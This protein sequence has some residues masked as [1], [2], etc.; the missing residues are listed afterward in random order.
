MTQYRTN[1]PLGSMA[2]RDLFD[3]AQN[4]DNW[5]NG[6]EPFYEDR[7]GVMRR[8]FSGMNFEFEAAQEGRTAAFDSSQADKES[9]F[10]ALMES[11]AYVSKGA[12]AEGVV[13]EAYNEYVAVDAATTGVDAAFYRP[14]PNATLPLTLSG[15]WVTDEPFLRLLGDDVLR[16]ELADVNG[17]LLV[18]GAVATVESIETLRNFEPSR[19]GQTVELLGYYQRGIG[20]GV[21][22]HDATSS[23]ADDG[24][25]TIVTTGGNRWVRRDATPSTPEMYGAIGD[26]ETDDTLA[27]HRWWESDQRKLS[28]SGRYRISGS[29][30]MVRTANV[31]DFFADLRAST[32]E[33]V[34]PRAYLFS[35]DVNNDGSSVY[36]FGGI[37]DCGDNV[38]RPLDIRPVSDVSAGVIW[39]EGFDAF[40]V[41]A[42]SG[43]GYSSSA[44]GISISCPASMV[45]VTKCRVDR[46]NRN[47][48]N[49]SI[50]AS[51]GIFVSN[52]IGSVNVRENIVMNVQSPEG[53][54]DADCISV[55]SRDRLLVGRQRV[56]VKIANNRLANGKG[57]F[58]KLQT[59]EAEVFG[60]RL[61]SSSG[62]IIASFRAIDC[63][64]G[65]CNIH[66][67][68]WN[69][70][71]GVTGGSEAVFVLT[72]FKDVGNWESKTTVRGNFIILERV[73]RYAVSV[74]LSG[75]RARVEIL[76]NFVKA[77]QSADIIGETFARM[78][79]ANIAAVTDASIQVSG[80]TY[81]AK[82]DAILQLVGPFA[83][84]ATAAAKF[85]YEITNNRNTSI[86]SIKVDALIQVA[87]ADAVPHINRCI[88]R[89]NNTGGQHR[90]NA[91]S[92]SVADMQNGNGFYFGTNGGAEGLLNAPTGYSRFVDVATDGR[93]ITLSLGTSFAKKDSSGTWSK[94]TGAAV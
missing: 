50:V 17:V 61:E 47:Y 19:N 14:G 51:V 68:T 55:F 11:S 6:E 30:E 85:F 93:D 34:E 52:V 66:D 20:G 84:D 27:V 7:F 41:F 92:L 72:Q 56:N 69:L 10:H 53:D 57:R 64:F 75:G 2:P 12:Y 77:T 4:V 26:G 28:A 42:N 86:P 22:F 9:R 54:A 62:E 25:M 78:D 46:V 16:Q 89:G 91:K 80:N 58:I 35:I 21:F 8:S 33:V 79:A 23:D 73:L 60:N 74:T 36:I 59:T 3:N 13:L 65:G 18:G 32:F 1:N 87:G 39:V 38:A 48:V 44:V 94:Y 15:D 29:A 81:A 45:I 49:E 37:V 31:G 71:S 24:G 90:L 82:R 88:L 40:N 43:L 70:F 5:A 83:T 63:Q 67:N 76:D